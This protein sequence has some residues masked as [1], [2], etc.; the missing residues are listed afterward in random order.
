MSNV[1][2]EVPKFVGPKLKHLWPTAKPD[3][4]K[5]LRKG[6]GDLI[7]VG[8]KKEP[9][10]KCEPTSGHAFHK[11]DNPPNTQFRKFYERGDL[12]VAVEHKGMKN[13]IIWKSDIKTL[14]YHHYL[15]IFFDGIREKEEPYR[16][17]A[18]KG[19][20]DLLKHGGTRIL[21]VIPQLII[22]VKTALNTRDPSVICITLQVLQL[23]VE[24]ADHV[25]EALGTG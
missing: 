15:P 17:L 19:V 14:D 21:H 6:D 9:M 10:R 18:V 4:S 12:P 8:A 23:L 11:R 24:S 25:G 2:I 5:Y 22:P 7:K 13:V 20:E 3:P 16:F 1:D